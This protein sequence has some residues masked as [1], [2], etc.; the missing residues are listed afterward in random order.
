MVHVSSS[1]DNQV[2]ELCRDRS[3]L[4]R[5]HLRKENQR[6]FDENQRATLHHMDSFLFWRHFPRAKNT[7]IVVKKNSAAADN[8][9]ALAK[10]ED[11][12][13]ADE[14]FKPEMDTANKPFLE[15]GFAEEYDAF[16]SPELCNKQESDEWVHSD[17]AVAKDHQTFDDQIPD[18]LFHIKIPSIDITELDFKTDMDGNRAIL[19]WVW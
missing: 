5:L 4:K 12:K 8:D 10:E 15:D 9:T 3:T 13:I 14:V 18:N 16:H 7:L 1:V 19:W 6:P 11:S 17:S 2:L